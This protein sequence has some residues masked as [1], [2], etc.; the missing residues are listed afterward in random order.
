MQSVLCCG[1][2][3]GFMVCYIKYS[4]TFIGT[5]RCM[6]HAL[7]VQL[8]LLYLVKQKFGWHAD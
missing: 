2:S 4:L 1:Q 5:I 7:F 8:S 3:L 6:L